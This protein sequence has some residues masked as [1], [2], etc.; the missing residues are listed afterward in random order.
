TRQKLVDSLNRGAVYIAQQE[1][2]DG[3]FDSNPG[4]TGIAL[5]ALLRQHGARPTAEQV[6]KLGKT[7]DFLVSLGK[8]D[9]GIYQQAIPHYITAVSVSALAIAGRP[10]DKRLIERGRQYL[11][12][13]MLDEGEGVQPGDKLYARMSYGGAS[14]QGPADILSLAYAR[15]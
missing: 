4:V 1:K 13:Q 11:V 5:T 7:L 3:T 6:K 15:R 8:P 12:E 9:G 14:A 10:Q 2:V